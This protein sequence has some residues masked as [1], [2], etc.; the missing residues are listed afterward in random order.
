MEKENGHQH[1]SSED[2]QGSVTTLSKAE[3]GFARDQVERLSELKNE[4]DWVLDRRMQAWEAWEKIPMPTQQDEEW[5][6]TDISHID[7]EDYHPFALSN[8]EGQLSVSSLPD[9]TRSL[10]DHPGSRG[11][12]QFQ[13]DSNVL[14]SELSEEL[15]KQ[16]VIFLS[17]DEAIQEHPELVKEY[18]FTRVMTPSYGKFAALNGAFWSG[19]SFL[20][21]PRGV[22]VEVPIEA[23][24]NVRTSELGI[25]QHNLIILEQSASAEFVEISQSEEADANGLNCGITEIYLHQNARMN[26]VSIQNWGTQFYDFSNKRAYLERDAQL[27][28]VVS[29]FGGKLVKNHVDSVNAGEGAHSNALGLYFLDGSQH[30]DTGILLKLN[31]PHTTADSIFKGVLKEKSRSVF[32]GLIKIE[33]DAQLSDA[34]LENKNLLLSKGARADSI[35]VLEIE[36]DDVQA[37]HGATVGRVDEDQMYY[38]MSRGL[39]RAQAERVIISGFF[40][41][42]IKHIR[43]QSTAD[44]IHRLVQQKIE[45]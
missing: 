25:F 17:I 14:M 44:L 21:V 45:K 33:R 31:V 27:T 32:Q 22:E 34:E 41:N 39:N 30:L 16:G 7:F 1:E 43:S 10:V 9:A 36:A 13:Y 6:R 35:P 3:K 24:V 29:T 26:H 23:F 4:P 12:W 20:Y 15:E 2:K 42:V 28:W 5:R 8:G 40:E 37:A 18:F 19:G 11:G 38:L